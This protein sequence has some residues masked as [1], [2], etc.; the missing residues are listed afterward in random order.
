MEYGNCVRPR[1]TQQSSCR[2]L[3]R[4][5]DVSQWHFGEVYPLWW[6]KA[7]CL[8]FGPGFYLVNQVSLWWQHEISRAI[9]DPTQFLSSA[10]NQFSCI[11]L[12]FPRNRYHIRRKMISKFVQWKACCYGMGDE[13]INRKVTLPSSA[14]VRAASSSSS[15]WR[16]GGD[17]L[18]LGLC[19]SVI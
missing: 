19:K 4:R 6:I 16:L 7:I 14:A 2:S 18:S 10:F 3:P 1:Q 11:G 5:T 15:C 9:A 12:S 13:K 17:F 8:M